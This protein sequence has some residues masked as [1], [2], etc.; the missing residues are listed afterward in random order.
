MFY[1]P[2]SLGFFRDDH[3]MQ[4]RPVWERVFIFTV[5][6][7]AV[8]WEADHLAVGG[9]GG[10][11]VVRILHLDGDGTSG[12]FIRHVCPKKNRRDHET[13]HFLLEEV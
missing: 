3:K 10:A 6:N 12:C 7:E 9:Q 11:V 4:R 1:L 13:L 8:L 5:D 2:V